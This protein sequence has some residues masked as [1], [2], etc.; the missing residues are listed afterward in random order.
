ML[1]DNDSFGQ[2]KFMEMPMTKDKKNSSIYKAS[3]VRT[4]E[5]INFEE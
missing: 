4:P 1:D 2:L 5:D 3:E